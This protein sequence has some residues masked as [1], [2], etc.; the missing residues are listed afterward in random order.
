MSKH[1]Y[2]QIESYIKENAI[3]DNIDNIFYYPPSD[4]TTFFTTIRLP[5]SLKGIEYTFNKKIIEEN[6]IKPEVE[7]GYL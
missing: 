3:Q 4:S 5:I 6:N 2:N 1:T 7:E